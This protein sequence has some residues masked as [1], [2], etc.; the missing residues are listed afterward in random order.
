MAYSATG[1]NG[2]DTLNQSGD[3]GPGTVVGLAGDDSILPGTGLATITGDSGNDT[4]V[5]QA[6]NTGT[7][8]GGT[9][10]DSVRADSFPGQVLTFG[11]D[12]ADTVNVNGSVV[13]QTIVG[14]NDSA[15]GADSLVGGS[16]ADLIFGNGG[17]DS[18]NLVL[19]SDTLVA[20]VGN[21]SLFTLLGS[22]GS[23]LYFG[24][25]GNDTL[26]AADGG[27]TLF[28]GLGNDSFQ[29][30]AGTPLIFGNE[31]ADTVDAGANTGAGLTVVGGN[32]S[33]DGND[34]ILTGTGADFIFGN[35]GADSVNAGQGAN[36]VV[37]GQ[38]GDSIVTGDGAD[39]IFANESN[40]TVSN[41]LGADTVFGGLGND[42]VNESGVD[43]DSIQGNE[44]N[45]TI[46]GGDGIDTIVG[47]AGNDVFRYLDPREDGDNAAGGGPVDLIADVNWAEDRFLTSI[48]VTF[49]TNSGAG[50]GTD[51]NASA[52]NAIAAAFALNGGA[53]VVAA[54]FTFG[55]RTYL[56]I[57]QGSIGTFVDANDLLVDITG[58]TGTIGASNFI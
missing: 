47:G 27:D 30:F 43:R 54:Q 21:D 55:G 41:N 34:S 56:A 6:G 39:L 15:D 10:N 32:D 8:N 22:D 42:S 31:G 38:G 28:A 18:M 7:V 5:L 49:A 9:E 14:G 48:A 20:G 24:N 25:E 52:N 13:D 58:A 36:T 2:N 33:A 3:T 44:G 19:G 53:G 11:G 46:R 35:G 16:G 23:Q 17:N 37:G 51:L 50:T 45:D 1:T 57:D 29:H 12:G 40:D 4:V 26:V